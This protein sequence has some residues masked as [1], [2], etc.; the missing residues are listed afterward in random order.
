MTG[1]FIPLGDLLLPTADPV[2]IDPPSR[3]HAVSGGKPLVLEVLGSRLYAVAPDLHARLLAGEPDAERDLAAIAPAPIAPIAEPADDLSAPTAL[4]LNL[5]QACNLSCAYCYA[6]EGRFGGDARLMPSE[7]ALEAI[8]R[9][10]A[11]SSGRRVTVGFIGGEP[12]LN[13]DVLHGC[14]AHARSEAARLG[15]AVGFSVTT[16]ATLLTPADL[17]LLRESGFAVSVSLDGGREANDR[18]RR[19]RH[20]SASARAM[21]AVGPLLR[22]PGSARVAA[23]VTIPRD[24]LRVG[25]RVEELVAAGFREVGVSP[26]RASADPSLNLRPDDWAAFLDEMIRAASRDWDR[27]RAGDS[28]DGWRFSNPAVALKEIHRGSCRP[29]PCGAALGY[30]SLG[31]S[32]DYFT[33]HRTVDDA[34]FR[35]GSLAT[36]LDPV[37]RGQFLRQRHVDRQEPCRSCWARYLC[38][39]GCHAEVVASGRPGCDYIRGWLDHCVA[40]YDDVLTER[41]D[42]LTNPP[43]AHR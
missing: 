23:R 39:G 27:V 13:R 10:L 18:Y 31:A 5:A 17:G 33:C 41:P 21:D 32:G 9:L 40:L 1:P 37:A 34:R 36:G 29:L 12:F 42:L 22:D 16:N 4:S 11:G 7:V 24:D 2:G 15:V 6:D 28:R 30:V 35:L 3:F 43:E 20:G 14:V 38:G 8:D 19:S 25:E 26:L